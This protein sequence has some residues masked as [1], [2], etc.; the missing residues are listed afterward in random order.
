M[1]KESYCSA[2]EF[3]QMVLKSLM[4]ER[5]TTKAKKKKTVVQEDARSESLK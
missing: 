5:T 3:G 4:K 1:C 2:F